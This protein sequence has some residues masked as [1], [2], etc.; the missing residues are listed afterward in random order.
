ME[1]LLIR[2]R[3]G[4]AIPSRPRKTTKGSGE[5]LLE[6]CPEV[7]GEDAWRWGSADL[8]HAWPERQGEF[9]RLVHRCRTMSPASP[10]QLTRRVRIMNQHPTTAMGRSRG[11]RVRGGIDARD[12][13]ATS[14]WGGRRQ[15]VPPS[16]R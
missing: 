3:P 6:L 9:S 5:R 16:V 12:Q 13:S 8:Y 15:N 11:V 1:R 2:E 10:S 4:P 7:L 14:R